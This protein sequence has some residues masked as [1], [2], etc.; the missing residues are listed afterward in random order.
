M[1]LFSAFTKFGNLARSFP[2]APSHG[3]QQFTAMLLLLGE[4]SYS[5]KRAHAGDGAMRQAM[6]LARIRYVGACG[7]PARPGEDRRNA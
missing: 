3:Q 4:R 2:G 6:H 1:P 5:M 7:P